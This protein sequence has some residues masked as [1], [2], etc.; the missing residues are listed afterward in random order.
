MALLK[1]CRQMFVEDRDM[2]R[3]VHVQVKR[4]GHPNYENI[5]KVMFIVIVLFSK[6][7]RYLLMNFLLPP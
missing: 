1:A 6:V 2:G 3:C 4:P 7:L 5:H